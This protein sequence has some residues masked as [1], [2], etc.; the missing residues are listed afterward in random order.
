MGDPEDSVPSVVTVEPPVVVSG[1]VWVEVSE[2][3]T[4]PEVASVAS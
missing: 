2:V 3:E 1:P 4:A